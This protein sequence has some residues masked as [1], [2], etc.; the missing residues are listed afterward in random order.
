M[1]IDIEARMEAINV[2]SPDTFVNQELAKRSQNY[3]PN[4]I[5]QRTWTE[6]IVSILGVKSSYTRVWMAATGSNRALEL[7]FYEFVTNINFSGS[8]LGSDANMPLKYYLMSRGKMFEYLL[9]QEFR[10]IVTDLN[11][12]NF[13][14]TDATAEVIL[15]ALLYKKDPGSF[16]DWYRSSDFLSIQNLLGR[17]YSVSSVRELIDNEV[18]AEIA[19]SMLAGAH[20]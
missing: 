8:S 3:A 13:G 9:K 20:A 18:D 2:V 4:V 15:L 1:S 10:R 19:S 5:S 7:A 11:G 17:G 6:F 16:A 14:G 12:M